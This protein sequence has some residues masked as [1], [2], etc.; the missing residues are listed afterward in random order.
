LTIG[1]PSSG[2]SERANADCQALFIYLWG[3]VDPNL[4]VSPSRGGSAAADWASTSPFKTI[5]LPDLRGRVFAGADTM[6]SAGPAVR[7]STHNMPTPDV[8]GMA[9]GFDRFLLDIDSLPVHNHGIDVSSTIF[10]TGHTH[11]EVGFQSLG[12]FAGPTAGLG[13]T[14]GATNIT[15]GTGTANLS[16][17]ITATSQFQ[18]NGQVHYTIQPTMIVTIYIRL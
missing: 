8:I 18:G 11:A 16:V 10:D 3:L 9:G 14:G 15:T 7:I 4:P 12:G 6:G 2:G 1:P 5:Q 17:S 13:N